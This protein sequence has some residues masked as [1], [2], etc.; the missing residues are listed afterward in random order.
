M[1]QEVFA[2]W[3]DERMDDLASSEDGPEP[4]EMLEMAR[5]LQIYTKGTF[6][7]E[8]N[9]ENGTSMMVCKEEQSAESTK[10]HRSF[11]C[12][13]RIFE[14]GALYS[15][16]MRVKFKLAEGRPK[17]SYS[18]HREEELVSDAFM[19]MRVKIEEETERPVFAGSA[20]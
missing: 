9:P 17:F 19:E 4:I 14:G 13:L 7:K 15:V 10:I 3:L 2:D 6:I 12:G 8:I 1:T 16:E 5:S 11:F 20:E 18:I